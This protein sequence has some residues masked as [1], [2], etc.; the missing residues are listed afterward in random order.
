VEQVEYKICAI[1]GT[2]VKIPATYYAPR[3]RCPRC[4]ELV[5]N[6]NWHSIQKDRK[7][8][9][10]W[11]VGTFKKLKSLLIVE[12]EPK[13][14]ELTVFFIGAAFVLTFLVHIPEIINW[15]N[16]IGLFLAVVFV[17][18]IISASLLGIPFISGLVTFFSGL[19]FSLYHIF[20]KKIRKPN[21]KKL[22]GFSAVSTNLFTGIAGGYYITIEAFELK[23]LWLWVFPVWTLVNSFLLVLKCKAIEKNE[24]VIAKEKASLGEIIFGLTV[25]LVGFGICHFGFGLYWPFTLSICVVYATSFSK[26]FGVIFLNKE[27]FEQPAGVNK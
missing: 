11:S 12:L 25:L 24:E 20:N 27:A 3:G 4:G 6:P 19:I 10:L 2:K 21:D 8:Q 23:N 7:T 14:D 13:F 15:Y 18:Y 17:V 16:S 5:K 9:E 22:M 26:A 1:C